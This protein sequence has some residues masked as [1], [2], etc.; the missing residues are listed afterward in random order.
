MNIIKRIE[1]LKKLLNKN[2][3][4]YYIKQNPKLSDGEYDTYFRELVKLENLY[5]Q[6]KDIDSPTYRIG[7]E[8]S[9]EFKIIKHLQPMMS[10]SDCFN[11][12]EFHSWH[13]RN[14]KILENQ[15][16]EMVS[17][18]KI[19]GLAISLIYENSKLKTAATRGDG[20]EGE[21][22]TSNARTIKSIPLNLNK[23]IPGNIEI[24]GEVFISKSQFT[25]LNI[26]REKNNLPK[27]SNPRNCA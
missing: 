22:V 12:E 23:N 2:N 27:Y 13:N 26:E 10:L 19:D 7:A 21:D 11:E 16:F 14:S 4:L 8:P 24:R 17:E 5:P 1:Y 18:L 3:Y 6:Y 9:T 15:N 20:K 25:S